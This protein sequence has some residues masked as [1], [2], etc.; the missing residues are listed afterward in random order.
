VFQLLAAL[1][2]ANP[3]GALPNHYKALIAPLIVPTLWETRGNI[4]GC[5][6][7]LAAILPRAADLIVAENQLEPVLGI[8]QKLLSGKKTDSSAFELLDSIVTSIPK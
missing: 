7:L 2:E 6:R 8:F 3:S 4:P 5:T 1:L